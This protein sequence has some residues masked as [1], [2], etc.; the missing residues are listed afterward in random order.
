MHDLI[1]IGAG[2]AGL[3]AG[4]YAGRFGLSTLI[5]EKNFVGGQIIL[6]PMIEN[7]P[8]FPVGIQTDK[9]IDNMRRQVEDLGI[10]ISMR[11]VEKIEID[12]DIKKIFTQDEALQAKSLIIA[13]GAYPKKLGVPGEDR[14]VGKG[15]SYCGTCDGPLFKDKEICV[16][17]GGDRALEEAIFLTKYAQKVNLI[18]RRS[19]FRGSDILKKEIGCN[20]KIN[21]VLDSVID[22]ICGENKVSSVKIKNLK[23]NKAT[24]LNCDGVFI[25]VGMHPNTE[26]LKNILQLDK[27]GFIIT[28]QEMRTSCEG[29]FAAGDCRQSPLWQV[30][31]ACG[32]GAIAAQGVHQYVMPYN[33]H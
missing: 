11:E 6:S 10:K 21:I 22:E 17:G 31:T 2:P 30:I 14:F 9:L 23:D 33:K 5:I 8:G 29:V 24:T 26:F 1:I 32:D 18:H 19:E 28:N 27:D 3:T 13:S 4:L 15:V 12:K 25:F 20:K 16:V 7:F